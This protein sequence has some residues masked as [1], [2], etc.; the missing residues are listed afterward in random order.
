L[1]VA[2][3]SPAGAEERDFH[4]SGAGAGKD[5]IKYSKQEL[6]ADSDDSDSVL[7]SARRPGADNDPTGRGKKEDE[8]Y[9]IFEGNYD[10]SGK[11]DY[12]NS[13]SSSSKESVE[14][15]RYKTLVQQMKQTDDLLLAHR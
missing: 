6:L 8:F 12:L 14:N 1:A 11:K 13:S 15:D 5:P 7:H 9:T 3:A 2:Q 4:G 10:G